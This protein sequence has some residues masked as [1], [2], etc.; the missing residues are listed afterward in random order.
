MHSAMVN[1]KTSMN[2]TLRWYE[3]ILLLLI[4]ENGE[5]LTFCMS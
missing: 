5:L 3:A 2:H 1:I 4:H